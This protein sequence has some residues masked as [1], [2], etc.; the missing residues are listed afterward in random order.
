M[1]VWQQIQQYMLLLKKNR[2]PVNVDDINE[3]DD[4]LSSKP[5][6]L[7]AK[8]GDDV[9]QNSNDVEDEG[10]NQNDDEMRDKD[11]KQKGN[12]VDERKSKHVRKSAKH[13]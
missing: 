13:D 5:G 8:S 2:S 6:L 4:D 7:E 3:N 9:K 10:I 11:V 1:H 12:A